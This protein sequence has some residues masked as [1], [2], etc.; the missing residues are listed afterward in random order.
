M[1]DSG[2]T[3]ARRPADASPA[4]EVRRMLHDALQEGEVG[5]H[6]EDRRLRER[7]AHPPCR[8]VAVVPPEHAEAA[9]PAAEA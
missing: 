2:S 8:F 6:A 3:A 1:S 9:T 7:C 4:R 5:L